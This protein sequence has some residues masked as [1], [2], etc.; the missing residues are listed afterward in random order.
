MKNREIVVTKADKGN[1]V[2]IMNKLDYVAKL[3]DFVG[4]ISTYESINSN[5]LKSWIELT[6]VVSKLFLIKEHPNLARRF[7]SYLPQLPFMYG[8]PKIHKPNNHLRLIISSVNSVTYSLSKYVAS[9]LKPL[10]DT[11]SG[12]LLIS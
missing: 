9:L 5:P 8:L 6:I 11:I 1:K 3:D 10:L 7:N 2:V 12:S 4:D